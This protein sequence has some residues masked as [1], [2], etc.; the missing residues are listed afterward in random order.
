MSRSYMFTETIP[1]SEADLRYGVY[2]TGEFV[3]V[4]QYVSTLPDIPQAL[5]ALEETLTDYWYDSVF[6]DLLHDYSLCACDTR[7][8]FAYTLDPNPTSGNSTWIVDIS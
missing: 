5:I 1:S 8:T 4:F 2:H 3:F 6:G 7:L